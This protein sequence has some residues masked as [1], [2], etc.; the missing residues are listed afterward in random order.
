MQWAGE[1][2]TISERPGQAQRVISLVPSTTEILFYLGLQDKV[3]G[4][5]EHCDFPGEAR[6]KDKVGLFGQP[7][8][9]AILSL[10]PDLVLAERALHKR[11]VE[12]LRESGV[13]VLAYS[14]SGVEDVLRMISEIGQACGVREQV[15]PVVDCLE[16]RV[17]ALGKGAG[18]RP[19]VFRLM[20]ANPYITTG[21]G[22]FQYDALL[23]AGAQMMD[24]QTEDAYVRVSGDRIKQFNPEIILFCGIAKGQEPPPRC[25]GCHSS[26][27]VCHRTV[28]DVIPED[29]EQVAA[30]RASRVYPIPCHLICRPGPRLIDG[31]EELAG[32][33]LVIGD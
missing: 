11:L 26:K 20:S 13:N 18:H 12:E 29:W 19:R 16:K 28:E 23:K 31:M 14:P 30:V 27:P 9:S 24:F 22:S 6:L 7:R 32:H 4:V 2:K 21:P 1:N 10:E 25:K 8:L 17:R 33:Y 15:R 5:T 3:V